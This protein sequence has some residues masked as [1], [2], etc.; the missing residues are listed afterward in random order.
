MFED[1]FAKGR[2]VLDQR[3]E[4][5]SVSGCEGRFPRWIEKRRQGAERVPPVLSLQFLCDL[6]VLCTQELEG[7]DEISQPLVDRIDLKL[8]RLLY[9][10]GFGVPGRED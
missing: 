4:Q 8:V 9:E 7:T 6:Q 2:S 1:Q 5:R 3:F 10:R